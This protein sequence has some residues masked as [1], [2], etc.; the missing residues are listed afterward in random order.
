MPQYMFVSKEIGDGNV[1]LF[2]IVANVFDFRK[3]PRE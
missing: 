2:V 1:L 3:S